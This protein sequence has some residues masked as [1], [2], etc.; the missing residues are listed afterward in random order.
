MSMTRNVSQYPMRSLPVQFKCRLE[1]GWQWEADPKLRG[2]IQCR[3]PWDGLG[4]ASVDPWGLREE[5]LEVPRDTKAVVEFL[6]RDG[7]H[8]NPGASFWTEADFYRWQDF[9]R[10]ALLRRLESWPKLG[11]KFG[12]AL[13][14]ELETSLLL[15]CKSGER[16]PVLGFEPQSPLQA[17]LGTV[18]ADKLIG[19]RFRVCGRADCGR[20][21]QLK[22]R[23]ERKFC[24]HRCA[25]TQNMRDIRL[26]AKSTGGESDEKT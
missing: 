18:L 25:H 26:K 12:P 22:R 6:N 4:F 13:V 7:M 5:F 16:R 11:Q 14:T 24:S 2:F 23:R 20:L 1:A 15:A 17:I 10:E 19:S 9:I 3:R 21:F 8:W